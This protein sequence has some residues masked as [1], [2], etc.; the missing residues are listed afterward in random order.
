MVRELIRV[1]MSADS[2]ESD[3]VKSRAEEFGHRLHL[4]YRFEG[5]KTVTP[6]S[7][8]TISFAR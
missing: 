2:A 3:L 5:V 8:S 4:A 6:T 7:S 1:V